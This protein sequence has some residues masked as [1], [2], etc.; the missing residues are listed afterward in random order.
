M[1][2]F[3]SS[4][5]LLK[6]SQPHKWQKGFKFS[7]LLHIFVCLFLKGQLHCNHGAFFLMLYSVNKGSVFKIYCVFLGWVRE[8]GE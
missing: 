7:H 3:L 4:S 1:V 5:V 6:H 2:I 8:D